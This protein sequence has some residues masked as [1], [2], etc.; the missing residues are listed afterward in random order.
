MARYAS[1]PAGDT[2]WNYRGPPS[3]PNITLRRISAVAIAILLYSAAVPFTPF[4]WLFP[5]AGASLLDTFCAGIILLCACWFQWQISGLKN[6]LAIYIPGPGSE[7]IRNGRIE[8]VSD[9]AFVWET[10][11]Y[12]PYI[13]CEALLLVF[14]EFG[15][16]ELLRRIIVSGILAGV[17]LV[18]FHATPRSTR[19]WAWGHIKDIWFWMVIRELFNAG[20]S[21]GTRR[22]RRY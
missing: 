15:A 17:W 21:S 10:N 1:K 16:N 6:N 18:G 2:S 8:R 12:W 13:A 9:V 4:S 11:N 22:R 7:T 5:A 19:M 20:P 14:A 3:G